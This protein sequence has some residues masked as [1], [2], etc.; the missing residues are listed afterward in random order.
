VGG[1]GEQVVQEAFDAFQ[2]VGVWQGRRVTVR[3]LPGVRSTSVKDL[4]WSA[5]EKE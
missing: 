1:I 2:A 3:A 5:S 4:T